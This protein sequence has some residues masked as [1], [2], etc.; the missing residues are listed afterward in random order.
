MF[1]GAN[2]GEARTP[3]AMAPDGG[4]R[5][6]PAAQ[7]RSYR[8]LPV[9][10]T[11]ASLRMASK[12]LA[13]DI[14]KAVQNGEVRRSCNDKGLK[15]SVFLKVFHLIAGDWKLTN[16]QRGALLGVSVS[17][18]QRWKSRTAMLTDEQLLRIAYLLNL[19]LDLRTVLDTGDEADTSNADSWVTSA[20]LAY[21]DRAPLEVMTKGT[22]I[23]VFNVYSYVHSLAT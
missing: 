19:Y 4:A 5:R 11:G 15:D 18:L 12:R 21:G 3:E 14:L 8:F 23:D 13:T 2:A 10:G 7:S 17:T 9:K 20:N 22:V 1:L 16:A 6:Q